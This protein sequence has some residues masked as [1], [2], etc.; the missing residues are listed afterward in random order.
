MI[1]EFKEGSGIHVDFTSKTVV[2]IGRDMIDYVTGLVDVPLDE[3]V[4][5]GIAH[6]LVKVQYPDL[7]KEGERGWSLGAEEE[8]IKYLLSK[9]DPSLGPV[10]FHSDGGVHGSV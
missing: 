7:F 3:D 10:E 9:L 4:V 5:E 2:L 1:Q 6:G 8:D